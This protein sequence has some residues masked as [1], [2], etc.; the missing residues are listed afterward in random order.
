MRPIVAGGH[1]ANVNVDGSNPFTRF[2]ENLLQMQGVVLQYIDEG[3]S[4]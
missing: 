4:S 2:Q 3:V 1:V